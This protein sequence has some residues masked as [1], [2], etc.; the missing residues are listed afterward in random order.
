MKTEI[1]SPREDSYFLSEILKDKIK[2]IEIKVLEIGCGSGIQL[3]TLSELGVENIYSCDINEFA[4]KQCKSLGFNSIQSNLFENINGKFDLIIFNPPY[5]PEDPL[6]SKSSKIITTA[7]KHGN[8]IINEFLKQAKNH[9]NENYR[10]CNP[11]PF[12]D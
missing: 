9:L 10:K 12:Q 4:V 3:E 8:E 1:Y 6:E 11:R 5:L 7:G 2:N